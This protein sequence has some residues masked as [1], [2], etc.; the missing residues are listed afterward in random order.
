LGLLVATLAWVKY[1]LVVLDHALELYVL[2]IG[3]VF[4]CVGAWLGGKLVKPKTIIKEEVI[5][6][7]VMV[8]AV[9]EVKRNTEDAPA[10]TGISQRELDVLQLLA[11]G[12]S[13]EEIASGLFVSQ[14]TVK[15]HLK[16]CRWACLWHW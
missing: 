7:E 13:N 4:V 14:N 3:I 16:Y 5:I 8:P 12:L 2:V 15:T 11:K 1:R 9:A 6:R 10:D